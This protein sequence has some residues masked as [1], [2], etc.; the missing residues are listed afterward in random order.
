MLNA[1][2]RVAITFVPANSNWRGTKFFGHFRAAALRRWRNG[3]TRREKEI[4]CGSGFPIR[5]CRTPNGS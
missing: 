5:F 1:K 4:E 3:G 2:A